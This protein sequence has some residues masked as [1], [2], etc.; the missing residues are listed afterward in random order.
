MYNKISAIIKGFV[1]GFLST[2]VA[3]CAFAQASINPQ[4]TIVNLNKAYEDELNSSHRYELFSQKAQKENLK[5]IAKL[6]N[7]LS[8]SENIH[9]NSRAGNVNCQ[10]QFAG[11]APEPVR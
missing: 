9:G 3:V 10:W 11:A 7:A 4:Q 5:Q 1:I 2:F 8:K 6:F